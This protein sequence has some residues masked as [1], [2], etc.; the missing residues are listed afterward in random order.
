M[1]LSFPFTD[2]VFVCISIGFK[3][4]CAKKHFRSDSLLLPIL[5]SF[6]KR[7]ILV[8]SHVHLVREGV[9]C[10][11]NP[12]PTSIITKCLNFVPSESMNRF[13]S[14]LFPHQF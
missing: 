10:E 6:G 3:C 2:K 9:F 13:C 8:L 11:T 12:A 1:I 14:F 5:Y 7:T 4:P